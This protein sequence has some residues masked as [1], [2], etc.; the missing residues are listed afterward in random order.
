MPKVEY[1]AE[2]NVSQAR[3]F[4]LTQDYQ[5]R[6]IWDP[7]ITDSKLL[8]GA[9]QAGV[10]VKNWVR[11]RNGFSMTVE[12][13]SYKP[14]HV[15]AMKMIDGPW[16]FSSFG[17]SWLFKPVGASSTSVTF[18]YTF[19]TRWPWLQPIVDPII[20]RVFNWDIKARV[21]SLK[22]YAENLPS[23]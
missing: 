3:A 4:E 5:L 14:P 1:T 17:G 9:S 16:F 7:F 20:Q 19:K 2:I 12:Y 21:L 18:Q 11:A 23:A 8:D 10:G 13:V 6:K 15:T 22:K